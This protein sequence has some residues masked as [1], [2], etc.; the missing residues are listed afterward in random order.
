MN[1]IKKYTYINNKKVP[2]I[3]GG[4]GCFVAGT[5][6]AVPNGYKHI[7]DMECGD[8]ILC[9]DDRGIQRSSKVIATHIHQ[10]EKVIRVT[11]WG[12]STFTL[13][14]NHWCLTADNEF[15]E[16][17][18]FAEDDGLVFINNKI[19]PITHI[20]EI[21]KP[22]VVYN[23]TVEKYHTYYAN[24]IKVH[25]KGGGKGG[26]SQPVPVEDPNTLFSTDL[27]YMT[28]A[29]GEGPMYRINP[30]G[31]QDIELNDSNIDDLINFDSGGV[32]TELFYTEST[33]GT[34]SQGALGVFGKQVITPQVFATPVLLKK[35][36]VAGIPEVKITLQQTSA[37]RWDAIEFIFTIKSLQR[38]DSQ[39]N[40]HSNSLTC[41]I[42]IY[43]NLGLIL[44]VS[45]DFEVNGKTNVEFKLSKLIEIPD[46]LKDSAGYKF[47]ITKT[48]NDSEA[49]KD[50]DAIAILGWNEID[51]DDQA[52]PRTALAGFALKAH[53][54]HQGAIPS[55]TSM[56]KGLLCKVPSNYNQPILESGEIDW[57][58]LEVPETGSN[59]YTVN[60]YRLQ[61]TGST[62]LTAANPVLYEGFWDGSFSFSW[63]QNP[64]W[65]VYDV[66]TN[67]SYGLG[68]PENNIDKFKFYK[69]AQ[70]CDAVNPATGGFD[71]V[72]G[73]ADGTFR[74]NPR[75]LFSTVREV[76][77]G[78]DDSIQVLQRRF[79]LDVVIAAQQQVMDTINLL[80]TVFRGI[81]IYNGSKLSLNV[82]LPDEFPVAIFNEGNVLVDSLNIRGVKESALVTGVEVTYIEPSNHYKREIIRIDDTEALKELDQVE[83]VLEVQAIGVT[84]RSQAMRF[85]QY[86]LASNK[87]IR[88]MVNFKIDS[89][90]LNVSLGDVIAV[91][92]RATGTAWGFGGR[93]ASNATVTDSNV[94]LEHFTSPSIT[95]AVFT[96]NTLPVGLRIIG[97]DTGKIALY[98]V[99][100]T[101]YEANATGNT[102]TGVDIVK[103]NILQEFNMQT[104]AFVAF[105]G[106]TANNVPTKKD[107]WTLGEI[108]PN[109]IFR[110]VN[111]KLFKITA[112]EI[113]SK[114][115][116]VTI[117]ASEYIANVY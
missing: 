103:C 116:T 55:V 105:S 102:S 19:L 96:S 11:L 38:M 47:S 98:A 17:G 81:L 86:L 53:A 22:T 50:Q 94:W 23:L 111:D 49:A 61:K 87:Y 30:N 7:E 89:E 83:N 21:E 45:Q 75:T 46:E 18:D 65:I 1:R 84:R 64:V 32:N 114:V 16:I 43:N 48:S 62:V 39:G 74:H 71:G 13:T 104:K 15:M 100:D 33:T 115:S 51:E 57:R 52:Y 14:P 3:S 67:T 63:T 12:G 106:W 82:D 68:I 78:L 59:G 95:A 93:V 99:S 4:K 8:T 28:L 26:G 25:N 6:I 69:V 76:L 35:G 29:F 54:E 36:N 77:T 58:E 72:I 27:V 70:Y 88:R 110:S 10:K 107:L 24:G 34:V 91:S 109:S 92:Q 42:S 5:K 80:T 79:I 66:L 85:G 73:F 37:N 2:F 113:D 40:V 90:G 112:I 41:N 20:E 44:L 31:P 56:V 101:N 108:D 117:D 9:F 97:Q 60:G